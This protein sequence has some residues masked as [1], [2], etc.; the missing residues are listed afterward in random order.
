[1]KN[2]LLI[3]ARVCRSQ[4][5]YIRHDRRSGNLIFA[6]GQWVTETV[7]KNPTWDNHR[8]KQWMR[9]TAVQNCLPV[10]CLERYKTK[11]RR[12]E[13]A[14]HLQK[15]EKTW[16]EIHLFFHRF[17]KPWNIGATWPFQLLYTTSL[18]QV[19]LAPL[20]LHWQERCSQYINTKN[21]VIAF[22]FSLFLSFFFFNVSYKDAFNMV[23]PWSHYLGHQL[24]TCWPN[25]TDYHIIKRR[26]PPEW[27][28][29]ATSQSM[30]TSGEELKVCPSWAMHTYTLLQ[31]RKKKQCSQKKP[32]T[33]T[34]T[35]P[36]KVWIKQVSLFSLCVV[37]L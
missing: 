20:S 6:R 27:R 33:K 16:A 28:L 23:L 18:Y 30:H 8:D 29:D 4:L 5:R 17:L 2:C 22:I 12:E 26:I 10:Q 34:K 15:N 14:N 21:Q 7:C 1:M 9:S 37:L 13:R 11:R 19:Y 3:V 36:V 31:S 25:Y 35:P 24:C 32:Q